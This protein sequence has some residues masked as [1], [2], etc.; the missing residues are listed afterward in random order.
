[1]EHIKKYPGCGDGSCVSGHPGGM[2]TN[3]G[4]KCLKLKM[5]PEE[6]IYLRKQIKTLLEDR[7]FWEKSYQKLWYFVPE[8]KI[9]DALDEILAMRR[10]E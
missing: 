8:N 6:R 3:G 4:C 5:L 1:M 10:G 9:D 7:N 2:H